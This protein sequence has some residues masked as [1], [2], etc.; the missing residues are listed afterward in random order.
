MKFE[1]DMIKMN[2]MSPRLQAS[3]KKLNYVNAYAL[4]SVYLVTEGR[5]LDEAL[6]K[7]ERLGAE[8]EILRSKGTITRYAGVSSLILSDSSQAEKISMWNNYWTPAKK[9]RLLEVLEIEGAKQ[10]FR[11]A[12]F[13]QFKSMLNTYFQPLDTGSLRSFR[14]NFL[15]DFITVNGDQATVVTLAKVDPGKKNLLYN[16][17]ESSEEVTVLDRQYL[18][19]TF[20]RI[21][22]D[23]FNKIAWMSAVLVFSVLLITYGRIEL[24]LVS[25]IPMMITWIWILGLMAIL[26]ISFNIINIIISALIFGLGDDY[27][28]FI[29]DGLVQEYKTGKKNLSSFKSSIVLS[30]ITTVAGLG[31]LI[32]AKHPALRS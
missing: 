2:Y 26:G 32:F 25:F 13:D 24:A 23:D 6:R 27:S 4:Q 30:A 17:F 10:K 20:V 11:P 18:T 19:G 1:P 28:L 14:E 3:E 12:V 31:V 9:T 22:N 21:I 7:N 29:M 5:S 15:D 16:Y 8:I